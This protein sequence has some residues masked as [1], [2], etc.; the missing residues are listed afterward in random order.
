MNKYYNHQQ[1]TDNTHKSTEWKIS[2]GT[3]SSVDYYWKIA[4]AVANTHLLHDSRGRSIDD[5]DSGISHAIKYTKAEEYRFI[6]VNKSVSS[7]P[8]IS[9]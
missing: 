4:L 9:Q 6:E 7:E 3:H 5:W 8:E 2:D 1:S